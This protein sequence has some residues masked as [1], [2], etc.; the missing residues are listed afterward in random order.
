MGDRPTVLIVDDA[1][2][3]KVWLVDLIQG[4]GYDVV[5]ATNEEEAREHLRSIQAG[6]ARYAAAF[7]DVMLPSCDIL[8][9][10]AFDHRFFEAS[11]DAGIRLC[12][13][14]R[15]DLQIPPDRLPIACIT[16]GASSQV[17]GALQEM[18]IP[19]IGSS[20]FAD[21]FLMEKLPRVSAIE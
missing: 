13:Y 15:R 12:R 9:I 17:R 20:F 6:T 11:R 21:Q 1:I 3:D 5:V 19:L 8:H 18:G 10:R 4:R 2:D 14:A 7:F 16:A